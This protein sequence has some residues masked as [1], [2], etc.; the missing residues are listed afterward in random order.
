LFQAG[1]GY[2]IG[3]IKGKHYLVLVAYSRG[4]EVFAAHGC[5]AIFCGW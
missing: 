5:A 1:E 4:V 3:Q 2:A